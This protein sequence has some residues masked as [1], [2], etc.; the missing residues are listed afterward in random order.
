MTKPCYVEMVHVLGPANDHRQTH[1]RLKKGGFMCWAIRRWYPMVQVPEPT[2]N[3]DQR[4]LIW[5]RWRSVI[6]TCRG[7][8][9]SALVDALSTRFVAALCCTEMA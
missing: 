1:V 6:E 5:Q 8:N 4:S 3:S 7:K 2:M 9:E